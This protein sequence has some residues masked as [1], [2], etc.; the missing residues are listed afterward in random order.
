MSGDRWGCTRVGDASPPWFALI[1]STTPMRTD[2]TATDEHAE[3]E[4]AGLPVKILRI[5]YSLEQQRI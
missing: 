1:A 5:R 3:N 4:Y 2:H